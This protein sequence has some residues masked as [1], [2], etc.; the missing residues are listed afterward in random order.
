MAKAS[1]L[2]NSPAGSIS[3]ASSNAMLKLCACLAIASGYPCLRWLVIHPTLIRLLTVELWLAAIYAGYNGA[4]VVY[5]TELMPVRIRTAGFSLAYS[6]AT[7][8]FGGFTPALSTF[9][10]ARTGYAAAPG[11]W[12]SAAACLSLFAVLLLGRRQATLEG[13]S[14]LTGATER[15]SSDSVR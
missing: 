9:L 5:L 8:L 11:V 10:I 7:A 15:L 14:V 6:L 13:S 4:M 12:L 3:A 1:S 2:T